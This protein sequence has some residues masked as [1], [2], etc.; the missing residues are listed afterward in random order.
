MYLTSFILLR[1]IHVS[2][3]I[4]STL[5]II[6]EESLYGHLDC[7]QFLTIINKMISKTCPY[8]FL[9]KHNFSF[10]L[11]KYLGVELLDSTVTF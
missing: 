4:S 3:C 9:C 6:L 5:L 8:K 1:F 2:V 10:L 7:F 11:G